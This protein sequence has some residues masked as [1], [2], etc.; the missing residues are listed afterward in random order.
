MTRQNVIDAK[1]GFKMST[2]FAM[3]K[4]CMKIPFKKRW[5]CFA[6][7]ATVGVFLNYM[8]PA[9]AQMSTLP[10]GS[11]VATLASPDEHIM[12]RIGRTSQRR[13]DRLKNVDKEFKPHS[14]LWF[15]PQASGDGTNDKPLLSMMTCLASLIVRHPWFYKNFC[16]VCVSSGFGKHDEDFIYDDGE[17]FVGLT[18]G[19]TN[20]KKTVL[21]YEKRAYAMGRGLIIIAGR[22]LTL[23]VS[24]PCVNVVALLDDSTSSDLTYQ[25]MFRALTESEGKTVGYIVDVNPLRTLKTLYDYT[26]VEHQESD[27]HVPVNVT[28]LTN[29]YLIDED[30]MF[31]IGEDGSRLTSDA[32]HK[33][34]DSYLQASRKIYKTIFAEA[35]ANILAIDLTEE[36]GLF[37]LRVT[38]R[39]TQS[40]MYLWRR[41]KTTSLTE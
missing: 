4:D 39:T 10:D 40:L 34:L 20:T 26:A 22:M 19:G 32:L 38:L 15:L 12:N 31:V 11:R 29:M 18:N 6:S 24:L 23:G 1:T 14:Q 7:P 17:G 33:K 41:L 36:F 9:N 8:G 16:I 2:L 35:A 25:K 21:D 5:E 30:K 3:G 28:T 13:G 37:L 27:E